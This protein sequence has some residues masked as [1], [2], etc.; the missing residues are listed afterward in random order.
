MPTVTAR[1]CRLRNV[2]FFQVKVVP[3]T[4]TATTGGTS[5]IDLPITA[6]SSGLSGDG[7]MLNESTLVGV[8]NV[9]FDIANSRCYVPTQ[10]ATGST[11]GISGWYEV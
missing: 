5:Y 3:G 1:F 2:V 10:A 7:S 6:G 8:G 4:T 9:V 11:L